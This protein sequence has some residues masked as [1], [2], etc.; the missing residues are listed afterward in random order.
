MTSFLTLSFLPHNVSSRLQ[1]GHTAIAL[2]LLSSIF[3]KATSKVVTALEIKQAVLGIVAVKHQVKRPKKY[4]LIFE[5]KN[6][7]L[8]LA[9]I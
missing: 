7:Y 5:D 9:G 2:Y 8:A 1:L 3:V 6:L 4:K